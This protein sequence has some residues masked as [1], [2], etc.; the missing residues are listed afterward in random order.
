M[1]IFDPTWAG[2]ISESKKIAAM[3]EAYQLPATP[4]DCV[5]PVSFAVALHLSVNA[6]NTPIPEFVRAVLQDAAFAFFAWA[7]QPR[8]LALRIRRGQ[9]IEAATFA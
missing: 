8:C 4:H 3:A 5:G 7:R 6:P 2:G 1:I 9:R